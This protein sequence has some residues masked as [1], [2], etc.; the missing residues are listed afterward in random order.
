MTQSFKTQYQ[1]PHC[2]GACGFNYI[3]AESILAEFSLSVSAV[4][5]FKDIISAS[6]LNSHIFGMFF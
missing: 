5:L 6:P 4:M 3:L 1:M 2:E